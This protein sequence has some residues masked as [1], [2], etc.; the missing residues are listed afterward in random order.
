M[1]FEEEPSLNYFFKIKGLE[2]L[3][4]LIKKYQICFPPFSDNLKEI[5]MSLRLKFALTELP[6]T[7]YYDVMGLLELCFLYIRRIIPCQQQ[8]IRYNDLKEILE[9]HY[10]EKGFCLEFEI[11]DQLKKYRITSENRNYF[12]DFKRLFEHSFFRMDLFE[13]AKILF[14]ENEYI[15]TYLIRFEDDPEFICLNYFDLDVLEVIKPLE[16]LIEVIIESLGNDIEQYKKHLW[17]LFQKLSI[18][19]E[20]EQV[21]SAIFLLLYRLLKKEYQ[22]RCVT[23]ST[24]KDIID[25]YLDRKGYKGM[26]ELEIDGHGWIE[27]KDR[28]DDTLWY[29]FTEDPKKDYKKVFADAVARNF[30]EKWWKTWVKEIIKVGDIVYLFTGIFREEPANNGFLSLI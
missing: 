17:E 3:D 5:D 14:P 11:L 29:T 7:R 16:D 9:R 10:Q 26:F 18:V 23:S 8:K 27:I 1:P 2:E 30:Y 13:L 6:F 19:S 25:K 4:R 24:F 15:L 20:R 21:L 22:Y 12:I 28:N